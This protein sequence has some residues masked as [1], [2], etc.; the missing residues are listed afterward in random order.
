MA[1]SGRIRIAWAY[2]LPDARIQPIFAYL[3]KELTVIFRDA[4]ELSLVVKRDILS[5]RM[6]VAVYKQLDCAFDPH[7]G[8]CVWPEM[9][10]KPGDIVIGHYGLG[11][12]KRAEAGEVSY[13]TMPRVTTT[14]LLR[15]VEKV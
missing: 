5:V 10:A 9:R 6:S 3:H 2:G 11:L 1:S 14:A 8:E 4:H 7:A 12:E 15:E 13:L